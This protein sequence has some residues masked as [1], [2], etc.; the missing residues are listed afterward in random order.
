MVIQPINQSNI[1][2]Y[3]LQERWGHSLKTLKT[4]SKV[5]NS[6]HLIH[7]RMCA[8]QRVR[9]ASSTEKFVYALSE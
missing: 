8:Y 3:K 7:T 1:Q 2:K 4:F 5:S 9:T 6:Y